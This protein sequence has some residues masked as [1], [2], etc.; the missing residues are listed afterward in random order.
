MYLLIVP[1]ILRALPP[2][3]NRNL[4]LRHLEVIALLFCFLEKPSAYW[5]EEF[6]PIKHLSDSRGYIVLAAILKT[7]PS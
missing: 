4:T 3:L 1:E 2:S 5:V 6:V 7:S